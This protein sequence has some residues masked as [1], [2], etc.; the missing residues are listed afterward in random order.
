MEYTKSVVPAIRQLLPYSRIRGWVEDF[1]M[2]VDVL[3]LEGE[4]HLSRKPV[5]RTCNQIKPPN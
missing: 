2:D 3:L 5:R 4:V 1:T